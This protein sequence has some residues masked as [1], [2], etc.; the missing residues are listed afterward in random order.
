MSAGNSDDPNGDSDGPNWYAESQ[1]GNLK[2]PKG[3]PSVQGRIQRRI[4][5]D[6]KGLR[7]KLEC[8]RRTSILCSRVQ[9][10][11]GG[12]DGDFKGQRGISTIRG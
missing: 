11:L 3:I 7:G 8:S 6:L 10:G 4:E 9:V 5:G 1:K 2:G 12:S